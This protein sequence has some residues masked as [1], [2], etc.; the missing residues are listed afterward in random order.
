MI[1][2]VRGLIFLLTLCANA[3]AIAAIGDVPIT[4]DPE[5]TVGDYCTVG[6]NDYQGTRYKEKI[7]VCYRDVSGERKTRVYRAYHIPDHCRRFYTVDHYIPLSM[8]GSNEFQNLWP[9]HKDI[10]ATRQNLEQETFEQLSAGEITQE[11][12][13]AV[14]TYAKQNP[15]HVNPTECH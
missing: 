12:A 1:R 2:C 9:E 7:P 10:K 6:G 4:P 15:P 5:L 13:I 14:V 8:G 11:Q 3:S